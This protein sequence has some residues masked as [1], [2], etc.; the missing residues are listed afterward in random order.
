MSDSWRGDALGARAPPPP[1][2]WNEKQINMQSYIL[3]IQLCNIVNKLL[4]VKT[5]ELPGEGG[6]GFVSLAPSQDFLT[7]ET[8]WHSTY[9]WFILN[10][11]FARIRRIFQLHAKKFEYYLELCVLG[12]GGGGGGIFWV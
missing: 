2:L 4:I 1:P 8:K 3:L 6:G 12:G 5:T 9:E 10:T 7:Y 11:S